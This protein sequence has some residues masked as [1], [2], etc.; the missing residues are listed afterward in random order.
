MSDYMKAWQ[1]QGYFRKDVD[2]SMCVKVMVITFAMRAIGR[3]LLFPL[4]QM[5]RE[6][7]IDQL[8]SLLLY[9]IMERERPP[10][11]ETVAE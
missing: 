11:A 4:G 7:F 2:P 3:E 6:E 1:E 8:V 9:G 5:P 10:K